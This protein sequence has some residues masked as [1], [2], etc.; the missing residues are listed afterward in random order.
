MAVAG[1][2]AMFLVGGGILAHAVHG[3]PEALGRVLGDGL[4]RTVATQL[5]NLVAGVLAAWCLNAGLTPHQVQADDKLL[6]DFQTHLAREGI[7]TRW[8]DVQGY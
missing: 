2:L 3:L 8:P 7:E 1:T 5:V 6:S 4:L